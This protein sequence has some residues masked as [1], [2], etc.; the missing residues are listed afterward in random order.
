M[1]IKI[2]LNFPVKKKD[3]PIIKVRKAIRKLSDDKI[4]LGK[5]KFKDYEKINVISGNDNY[6]IDVW[7][8]HTRQKFCF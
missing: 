2:V 1:E 7:A 6:R 3:N 4:L 5:F 8:N